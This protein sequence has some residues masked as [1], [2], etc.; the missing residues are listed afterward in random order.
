MNVAFTILTL[1]ISGWSLQKRDHIHPICRIYKIQYNGPGDSTRSLIKVQ[2]F[3]EYMDIIR[4]ITAL[5]NGHNKDTCDAELMYDLHDHIMSEVRK[6]SGGKVVRS[7]QRRFTYD[8]TGGILQKSSIQKQPF[9]EC[10]VEVYKKDS[11][12]KSFY[13]DKKHFLDNRP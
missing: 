1:I 5:P 8:S 2:Y 12:V 10:Y 6:C 7:I 9:F 4:E 13:S 11:I 3:N